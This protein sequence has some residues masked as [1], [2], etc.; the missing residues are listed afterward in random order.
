MV[1]LLPA[2]TLL[3]AIQA[4]AESTK[5]VDSSSHWAF[6]PISQPQLPVVHNKDWGA[7]EIDAF[8]LHRLEQLLS[9]IHI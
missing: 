8:I 1:R 2:L 6:Q 9:L 5:K 7:N 4:H 3:F